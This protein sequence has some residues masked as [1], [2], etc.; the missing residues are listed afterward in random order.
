MVYFDPRGMGGSEAVR[1]DAEWPLAF[2]IGVAAAVYLEEYAP[3]NRLSRWI[4]TTVRNLAGVP[5]IVYG[6]LGLAVFVSIVNGIGLGGNTGGKNVIA[7]GITMAVVPRLVLPV[8][9]LSRSTRGRRFHR[10]WTI[11]QNNLRRCQS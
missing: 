5:S 10:P 6:L 8:R 7:A 11:K 3:D 1:E 9:G 4:D 2:P